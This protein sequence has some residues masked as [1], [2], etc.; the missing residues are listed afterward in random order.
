MKDPERTH[1][2]LPSDTGWTPCAPAAVDVAAHPPLISP[3]HPPVPLHYAR[4]LYD[5]EISQLGSQE[6]TEGLCYSNYVTLPPP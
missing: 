1:R 2:Q 3:H 5:L 4:Q 6:S